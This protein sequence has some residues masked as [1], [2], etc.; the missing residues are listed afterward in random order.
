MSNLGQRWAQYTTTTSLR[1]TPEILGA[2]R[3]M[4]VAAGLVIGRGRQKG[5]GSIHQLMEAIVA[6]PEERK[7]E[8]VRWLREAD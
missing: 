1:S 2:W 7:A 3:A 6:L 4:A 5:E 8:L